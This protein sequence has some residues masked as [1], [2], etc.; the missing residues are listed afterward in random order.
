MQIP[1]HYLKEEVFTYR[2]ENLAAIFILQST[3]QIQ[4]VMVT[5]VGFLFLC[6]G[7]VGVFVPDT[8]LTMYLLIYICIQGFEH[9]LSVYIFK[10]G[11][12]PKQLL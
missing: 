5:S 8:F 12:H 4:H 10:I 3:F 11:P 6:F 1:N 9:H 2:E 7:E